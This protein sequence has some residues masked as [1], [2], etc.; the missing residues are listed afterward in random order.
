MESMDG[1]DFDFYLRPYQNYSRSYKELARRK[2]PAD[3]ED[4]LE[5]SMSSWIQRQ[6]SSHHVQ[7]AGAALL[8]G[9]AVAGTIFGVQAIRRRVAMDELKAS[10]PNIDED[11]AS[12]NVSYCPWIYMLER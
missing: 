2:R 5:P 7:L 1:Q 6:A 10:I 3:Q 12:R 4:T 11:H 9:A 8:G